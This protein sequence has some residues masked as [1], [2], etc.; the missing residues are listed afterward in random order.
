MN[1]LITGGA[2]FIGSHVVDRL[3]A[4]GHR[5][6]A[7]DNLQAG[8]MENLL[9]VRG[10]IR[11]LRGDL[12]DPR[13]VRRA[14]RGN[15]EVIHIG[16]NASV[17]HSVED[18][19]YDFETNAGGTLNLLE[20]ARRSGV[21]RFLYASSAAVYGEP[22]YTPMDETHPLRPISPY[23]ASKLAGERL[24]FA[25]AESYGLRFVAARIF[26]IYGSRQPRY[27]MADLVRKLE[28]SPNR[29]EV[30]GDGT[31]VRD[32]CYVDDCVDALL[33]LFR[34]GKGECY[35]VAAGRP[36]T[37]RHIAEGLVARVS[38]GAR[39]V[40]T[41]KSWAGDVKTLIADVRKIRRLG[42]KSKVPLEE[43]MDRFVGWW[44]SRQ[45]T[46]R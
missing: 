11:F 26:N 8:K 37:I 16:A 5:V 43:G 22:D 10:R 41:G 2:G 23:G 14:V 39:I 46:S 34:R 15:E 17:P 1:I 44:E 45:T 13:A 30:L 27:V 33:F 36:T 6:T 19:R 40:Y 3:V 32:P 35:N 29:L 21:R 12:R 31:Q 28:R 38:P 4:L 7:L 25:Y 18:P 9:Q 20:A 42:W 24:G